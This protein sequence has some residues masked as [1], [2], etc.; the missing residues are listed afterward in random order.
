[1]DANGMPVQAKVVEKN[2]DTTTILLSDVKRNATVK[3]SV[4]KIEP[5]KDVKIIQG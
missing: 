1:V 4:F 2:N 3:A 5:P